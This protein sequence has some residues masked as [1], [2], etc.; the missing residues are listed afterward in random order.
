MR[1]AE[2]Q[3]HYCSK[4][5][6]HK[7]KA[8]RALHL[9]VSTCF[10]LPTD[11][12]QVSTTIL[13]DPK[14]TS[15]LSHSLSPHP[16]QVTIRTVTHFSQFPSPRYLLPPDRRKRRRVKITNWNITTTLSSVQYHYFIAFPWSL[17]ENWARTGRWGLVL[18]KPTTFVSIW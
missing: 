9:W 6:C 10:P 4:N 7:L 18:S 15:A 13:S 11:T 12:E 14:L 5:N 8:S 1:P 17:F 2:W 16:P 3:W